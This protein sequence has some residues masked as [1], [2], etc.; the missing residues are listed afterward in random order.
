VNDEAKT[1]RQ[2]ITDYMA[3]EPKP[4]CTWWFRGWLK[5]ETKTIRRELEKM[6]REG[7]VVSDHSQ[8]NNTKW[9]LVEAEAVAS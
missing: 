6:E 3:K 2:Q 7:L 5:R 8:A 4:C 9:K 1:L